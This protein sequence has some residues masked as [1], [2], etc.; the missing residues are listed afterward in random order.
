MFKGCACSGWKMPSGNRKVFLHT[1]PFLEHARYLTGS[2]IC[3]G[4]RIAARQERLH[5]ENGTTALVG[6][7]SLKPVSHHYF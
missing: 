2:S 7:G 1:S 3:E 4:S 5:T 6:V